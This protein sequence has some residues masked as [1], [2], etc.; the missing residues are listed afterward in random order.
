MSMGVFALLT[1][2]NAQFYDEEY[3]G[4]DEEEPQHQPECNHRC[5]SACAAFK[6]G[7]E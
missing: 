3:E 5:A 7:P 1:V 6:T 4:Y 2:G